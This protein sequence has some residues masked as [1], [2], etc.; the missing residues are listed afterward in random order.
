VLK[1][2]N[3][4]ITVS[5]AGVEGGCV[6]RGVGYFCRIDGATGLLLMGVTVRSIT[7]HGLKHE[8]FRVACSERVHCLDVF[9][10]VSSNSSF[11]RKICA[12]VTVAFLAGIISWSGESI[13]VS[14]NPLLVPLGWNN[15]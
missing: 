11:T 15:A 6:G 12:C 13:I 3:T 2:V 9:W 7:G 4:K 8:A 1:A 5:T 10:I 14:K